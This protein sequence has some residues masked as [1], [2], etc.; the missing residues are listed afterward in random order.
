MSNSKNISLWKKK[1]EVDYIPLFVS[2]WLSLNAWLKDRFVEVSNDRDLI[3]L[4][5]SSGD[6][7]RDKFAELVQNETAQSNRFKANLAELQKALVNANIKYDNEHFSNTVISFDNCMITWSP[8]NQKLVSLVK[9]KRQRDKIRI[10][11]NLWLDNDNQRLFSAYIE[12]TYQIR[13]LLFH[14]NLA[15]IPDNERVIKHLYLTL[16]MIME[17]V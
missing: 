11:D 15:P 3:E 4:L 17:K 1:S 16:S 7:L 9:G 2:L 10:D 14:G 6:K 5:K 13:C 12:I 8:K